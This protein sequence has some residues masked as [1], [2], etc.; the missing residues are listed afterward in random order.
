MSEVAASSV[1]CLN[2]LPCL[3]SSAPGDGL[4]NRF[5][6]NWRM[7]PGILALVAS[8]IAVICAIIWNCPYLCISFAPSILASTYLIYLGWDFQNLTS[9]S[10]SNDRLHESIETLKNENVELENKLHFFEAENLKLQQATTKMT[11]LVTDLQS[12]NLT[13]SASNLKLQQTV[14]ELENLKEVLDKKAGKHM[15]HLE[16]LKGAL[17]GLQ[18]SAEKDHQTFGENLQIFIKEVE[19]LGETRSS[20]E[21]AESILETKMKE[22]VETLLNATVMLKEIFSKI[23]EWKDNELVKQQITAQQ[24]LN[25]NVLKLRTDLAKYDGRIEEQK[26][27]VEE[28]AKLKDGF[29]SALNSLLNEIEHLKEL[30]GDL[31]IDVEQVKKA[32]K[33]FQDYGLTTN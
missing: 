22:Q 11:E 9:F 23:N 29:K 10:E 20:F 2:W 24:M 33:A 26:K 12:E 30:R 1:S 5:C 8:V 16:A 15:Q 18:E 21:K 28:L 3:C 6:L 13:L 14:T 25:E 27:Q 31:Q 7:I 17:S 4:K 32:A 19:H